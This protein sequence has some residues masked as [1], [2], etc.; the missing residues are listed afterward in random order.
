MILRSF[1]LLLLP[2]ALALN[3]Q[4]NVPANGLRDRSGTVHAFVHATVH[5]APDRVL[6]NGTVLVRDGRILAVGDDVEVPSNAVV[7]DLHGLHLWPALVEPV[8]ELGIQPWDRKDREK[9]PSGPHYWNPAIHA[10]YDAVSDIDPVEKDLETMRAMGFGTALVHRRDG[11]ARGIGC[12]VLLAG[13]SLREDVLRERATAHFSFRKGS[14]PEPY[15]GSLTGSIALLRQ[16][17]Y[18]AH[19]YAG[20]GKDRQRD[21]D[22]EALNG[23]SEIPLF[24]EAH[25]RQDLPR[26]EDLASEFGLRFAVHASGTEYARADAVAAMGM[27]L[28]LPL[29]FPEAYDVEDPF[30][31][32]EVSLADLKHWELAPHGPRLL[33]AAGCTLAFTADGLKKPEALWAALRNV[34][35]CG[36]DTTTALAAL[37]T[38]PAR[39]VGLEGVVGSL[40]PGA[41]ANMLVTSHHLLDPQNVLF[42]NWVD[43][44]PFDLKPRPEV[45]LRG[46]YDLNLRAAILK[47][48]VSGEPGKLKATVTKAGDSTHTKADLELR[49]PVVSLSFDGTAFGPHG[50]VR[51]NGVVHREGAIWDGQGQLPDGEWTAWSAVRQVDERVPA[52]DRK[53]PGDS[54]RLDS[55]FAAPP[56]VLWYPLGAYGAPDVPAPATLLFRHATVWTNGPDGILRDADVLVHE[57][58]IVAVGPD[59]DPAL[60]FPGKQRP[61][62]TEIDATG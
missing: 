46:V 35:R 12:V 28:I 32:L 41:R 52:T 58:R 3:A 61:T 48:N 36:L 56:G 39:L 31:A 20:T 7:H 44:V 2:P 60:L 29:T 33:D 37:T 23:S 22:L 54:E 42:A 8:S 38:V 50:P 9:R 55:L 13:R 25:D 15:P 5:P 14:S 19:W 59:L 4:D 57:G 47:L 26:I 10:A 30:D 40:E 49:G 21:L 51:L 18:D 11:I 16:A 53:P 27:P 17:F 45:D 6:R 43:G 62:V 34:V 24:F 1:A